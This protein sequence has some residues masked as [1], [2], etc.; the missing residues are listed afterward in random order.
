MEKTKS[1]V[2]TKSKKV[3]ENLTI[4]GKEL[5]QVN[6]FK[7][8]GVIF[9]KKLV[10]KDNINKIEERCKKVI[11]IMRCVRGY[12]WGASSQAL[13]YMYS[14]MIRSVID[15][16]NIVY[17]S[18]S[19][20]LMK[21]IEIIQSQALRVCCGAIKTTPIVA[22]QVEMGDMPIHLRIKQLALNYWASIQGCEDNEHIAKRALSP[23][24]ESEKIKKEYGSWKVQEWAKE[25]KIQDKVQIKKF[26][27]TV[28]P[29]WIFSEVCV[30]YSIYDKIRGSGGKGNWDKIT[31]DRLKIYES[32]L[33]IFTD[34]SKD[35]KGGK[36]GFAFVIPQ[37]GLVFRERTPD[38]LSV[39]TV[40]MLAISFSLQWMEQN[41]IKKGI[42]CTDSLSV[43]VSVKLM[44]TKSRI[45]ILYEIY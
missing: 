26:L 2:F 13:K 27:Y 18:A 29:K 11:N 22:I 30:D 4:Y 28:N 1:M 40:E 33:H 16:G 35:I 38:H 39:Y 21:R 37:I 15:Y 23:C 34:G 5:E 3:M 8:L 32:F 42:I 19:K 9:D 7:Y 12:E 45:D 14:A 17:S 43:L 44:S 25:S 36:T 24:W 6:N 41:R 10:W 31:E 20:T